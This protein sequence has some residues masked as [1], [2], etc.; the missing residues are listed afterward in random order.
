MVDTVLFSHVV[1]GNSYVRSGG[2]PIILPPWLPIE[3]HAYWLFSICGAVWGALTHQSR[4]VTTCAFGMTG[5]QN[6]GVAR[7]SIF[8]IGIRARNNG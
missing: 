8:I 1:L 2:E 7:M 6:E 4:G 3:A 5:C